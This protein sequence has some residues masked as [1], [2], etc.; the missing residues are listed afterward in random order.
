MRFATPASSSR[1]PALPSDSTAVMI[2]N[3]A[4]KIRGDSR[5]DPE[6]GSFDQPLHEIAASDTSSIC[7]TSEDLGIF[8][9][10]KRRPIASAVVYSALVIPRRSSLFLAL[11]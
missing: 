11:K 6:L 9:A 8:A 3:V 5:F 1:I 2:T 4:L 7:L 10:M